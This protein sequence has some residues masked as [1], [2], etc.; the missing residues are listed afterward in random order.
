M[1]TTAP[2][3]ATLRTEHPHHGTPPSAAAPAGALIRDATT[4]D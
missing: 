1:S 3:P 2:E 4:R